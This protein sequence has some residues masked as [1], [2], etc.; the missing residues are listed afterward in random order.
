[1]N[2]LLIEDLLALPFGAIAVSSMPA[3]ILRASG[4]F[5]NLLLSPRHLSA[6]D[7]LDHDCQGIAALLFLSF[8]DRVHVFFAV[9]ITS[10]A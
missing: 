4:Q 3:L 1:M 6:Y 2:E 7:L 9:V 5:D 8:G 10:G